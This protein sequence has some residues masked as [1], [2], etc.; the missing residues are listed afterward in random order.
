MP[1]TILRTTQQ[2]LKMPPPDKLPDLVYT[3]L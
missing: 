2:V 1:L 3:G